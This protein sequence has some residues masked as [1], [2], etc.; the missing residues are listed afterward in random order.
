MNLNRALHML[1]CLQSRP[2]LNAIKV[3][4]EFS[5]AR[6]SDVIMSLANKSVHVINGAHQHNISVAV[7]HHF[8]NDILQF[9]TFPLQLRSATCL[10]RQRQRRTVPQQ[11]WIVLRTEGHECA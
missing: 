11:Q 6:I 7:S 1:T 5:V 9:T 4:V 3:S 2:P 10:P 8:V